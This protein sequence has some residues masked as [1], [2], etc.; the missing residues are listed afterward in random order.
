MRIAEM[1][2]IVEQGAGISREEADITIRATLRTLAERITRGRPFFFY[3]PST[4]SDGACSSGGCCP[5][6]SG[7]D[8]RSWPIHRWSRA[9]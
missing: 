4:T 2:E 9:G 7:T 6:A 8:C 3:R 5:G 1:L